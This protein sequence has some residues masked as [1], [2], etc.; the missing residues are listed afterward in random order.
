MQDIIVA[1]D[2]FSSCGKSTLAK[3]LAKK[4][5]YSYVDTGAMY[6]AV[7][8][9][10]LRNEL[11]WNSMSKEELEKT[12]DQIKIEFK[13]NSE[14]QQSETYLNGENIEAE[15]RE[16]AVSD[17]VSEVSQLKTIRSRMVEL[18]QL[19]GKN[20][21]LV[22]DGRDIGSTVFPNAELKLF[23]TA[24]PQI[25]AKRR[26]DELKAKGAEITLEEVS[27][28]LKTRD[29]NDTHRKETPLI[30]SADAIEIDNSYLN[31]E[32]QLNLVLRMVEEKI[33]A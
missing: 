23:M 16:K 11:N 26:Y 18:Q 21:A 28:N 6:R 29:Y 10:L 20:K 15:I 19:A 30:R 27:E 31:E 32:E 17:T 33:K 1:I 3:A 9:Y 5:N 25:R 4:M 2:G 7:T 22:M 13:F 14:K 12:L 8:L 24:D